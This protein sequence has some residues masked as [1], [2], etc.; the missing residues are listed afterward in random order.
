MPHRVKICVPESCLDDPMWGE[1]VDY[2]QREGRLL[3]E[4]SATVSIDG[5]NI[6]FPRAWLKPIHES[7]S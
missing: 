3:A 1:A 2:D 4:G 7:Q 6:T 5:I